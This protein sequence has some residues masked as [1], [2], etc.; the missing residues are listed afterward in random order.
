[1]RVLNFLC[2][3]VLVLSCQSTP[4]VNNNIGQPISG[5]QVS[6]ML[7]KGTNL[8]G[9]FTDFAN[10]AQF[11]TRFSLDDLKRIKASGFVH[12]RLPIA[13]SM[14]FQESS[15]SQLFPT[16]LLYVDNAVKNIIDA[17]LVVLLDPIHNYTEDFEKKLATTVGYDD[18]VAAYW[19]AIATYFSKYETDKLIFEVYNEPHAAN[20]LV[21]GLSKDWWWPV[22]QKFIKA[23]R[24]VTINHYIV[25]GAEGWN[26]RDELLRQRPYD[27][28]NIVYNFHIYDPF[29]FTHQGADWAG[30]QPAKEAANVPYP[31]NPTNV[32]PLVS[33]ATT[34]VTKDALTWYGSQNFNY[35]SLLDLITPIANW[36]K[37]NNVLVTCNEFG[38]YKLKSPRQSRLNWIK[39]MRTALEANGT[40]WAMW[41]CDEGFGWI[42]YTNNDRRN[43]VVDSEVLKS[44]G[45]MP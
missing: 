35:N 45:L 37:R 23:I 42:D 21:Q 6:K 44:L 24:K 5:D 12:V 18:K 43:P 2:V 36:G 31:S 3:C 29:L 41:D 20:S 19:Q 16:N 34:Q 9:W 33:A 10:P 38:A 25:A 1:M 39:D 22:Q 4:S 32:A 13:T 15:P 8:S 40:P 14:L 11:G 30:W 26:S 17:G 7:N 27:E 28:V